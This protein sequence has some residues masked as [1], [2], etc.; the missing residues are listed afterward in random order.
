MPHDPEGVALGV[1]Q[2]SILGSLLFIL[3]VNDLPDAAVQ[4]SVLMY[5]DDTVLFYSAKQASVIEEKLNEELA[6]IRR[7]LHENS[8]FLNIAKTEA[9][10]FGTALTLSDVDSFS[11]TINDTQVKQIS[12]FKYLGVIFDERLSWNNHIKY[13]LRKAGKR[14]E[15]LG[16]IRYN[17][18]YPS[19]NAVYTSLIRPI[20]EYCGSI[21]GCCG[22]VNS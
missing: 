6:S 19:A 15:L 11:I 3:R 14:V 9:M 10:L 17:I 20:I 12:Q 22:Q 5:A 18:S 4:C 21:W 1:P 8:L 2:G 13:L 7:W 16:R